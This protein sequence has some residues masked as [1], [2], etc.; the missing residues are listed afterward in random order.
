MLSN[1]WSKHFNW[2][3]VLVVLVGLGAGVATAATFTQPAPAVIVQSTGSQGTAAAQGSS[4]QGVSAQAGATAASR[5]VFGSVGSV[6]ADTLVVKGQ[7]G[8][9]NVKLA[10]AKIVK[11]VD[12]AIADLKAGERVTVVAQQES[13]GSYTASSVQVALADQQQPGTTN[14]QGN[15]GAAPQ[16]VGN[17][18]QSQQNGGAGTSP[19]IGSV[20]SVA[21][22]VMT[23]STQQNDAKVKLASAKIEKMVDGTAKDLQPGQQVV[24]TGQQGSDGSVA[25]TQI[26]ILPAGSAAT[27]ARGSQGSSGQPTPVPTAAN[28]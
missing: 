12:G 20:T 4:A 9:V 6:T 1:V 3:V 25:A 27:P 13:D 19:L 26:D 8:D 7:Q 28:K 15:G 24:V 23:I 17:R 11:T 21:N 5:P 10:G 14:A 16:G 18:G 2:L 22:G